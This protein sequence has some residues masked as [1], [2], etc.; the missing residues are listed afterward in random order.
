M[1]LLHTSDWHLGRTFHGASL[2]EAQRAVLQEIIDITI[3]QQVD[4]VLISGDIYD[5]ALPH[6]DAVQLCNW[7]LRELRATGATVVITSGNHDSASRLG[8]G[9]DL[10]DSAGVHIIADLERMLRPVICQAEDHQ[11]AIYGIPYLEPRMVMERLGATHASHEAVVSAAITQ[12]Q[13]NLEQQRQ[14]GTPVVSI[15]MAHLFAAGGIGSDSERELS[16]GNLDVVSAELFEN[17]DYSALGHLH[18]RQ[19]VKDNVRYSGSPLAYSFSEAKQIKGVWVID[20]S[21]Q[22]IESIQEVLLAVPKDL[23]ILKGNLE[24]L[25]DDEQFEYA[26]A[27]WCQVTLTDRERPADAMARVRTRFPDTVVL[28]FAPEGGDENEK[29]STYAERMAKATSTEQVV[30]DFMEHVRE[31]AADEA[32]REVITSVIRA[33]R[34]AKVS[35]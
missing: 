31:R 3:N 23:A 25:L 27:A 15:A 22:G 8:F 16:T 35:Q 11:V 12:I 14:A 13:E 33:T 7:V 26:V 5:R 30:G 20:T 18:G 29:P 6:V 32:E 19:K 10:L 4:V 21:A 17:F 9:A 1:R 34:E 28:N 2:I 24:D